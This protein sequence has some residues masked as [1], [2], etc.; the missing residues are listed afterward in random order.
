H[1]WAV[2]R[3]PAAPSVGALLTRSSV[4][5][6]RAGC[7]MR[8]RISGSTKNAAPGQ[9]YS[10]NRDLSV[11]SDDNDPGVRDREASTPVCFVI[12]ANLYVLRDLHIFVDDSSFDDCSRTHVNAAH[13]HRVFY[14]RAMV[15]IHT[16]RNDGASHLAPRDDR[17]TTNH[18]VNSSA[19]PPFLVED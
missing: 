14:N 15:Q 2:R 3:T 10:I 18:R 4:S 12:D 17:A 1:L 11:L 6:E 13:Q 16:R 8:A 19:P 5:V 7:P 9:M